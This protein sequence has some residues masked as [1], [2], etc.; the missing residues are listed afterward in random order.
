M[1]S[2]S[3]LTYGKMAAYLAVFFLAWTLREFFVRREVV[4]LLGAWPAAL[5]GVVAKVLIWTVPAFW[6]ERHYRAEMAVPALFG[7]SIRW[8]RLLLWAT[9][10][11]AY[12]LL[13]SLLSNGAI[14][15]H[16][17]FQPVDLIGTVLFVGITEEMVFRGFLLNALLRRMDE[18]WALG[19]SSMLF[20]CIHF[21]IWYTSGL[22]AT[23]VMLLRSCLTIFVLGV[24]FGY[25]FCREKNL[26]VPVFLHMVWNLAALV[27]FG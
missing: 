2:K 1:E 10:L 7:A 16:P 4:Q 12:N 26:A 6:L 22:F 20:V 24:F 25:S 21:P 17:Q 19:I 11:V 23:P 3:K 13:A 8:G 5:L 14:R 9:G 15:V 27:L 18:K